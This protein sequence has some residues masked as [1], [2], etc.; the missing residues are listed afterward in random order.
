M[1]ERE[2]DRQTVCERIG[3]K[4]SDRRKRVS[5]LFV[6]FISFYI[7]LSLAF[8]ILIW[9]STFFT[10]FPPEQPSIFYS[11]LNCVKRLIEND[12]N[13][14]QFTVDWN[15]SFTTVRCVYVCVCGE[16]LS[17]DND[18][19]M[20]THSKTKLNEKKQTFTISALPKTLWFC[21]AYERWFNRMQS[22]S[23]SSNKMQLDIG[24]GLN[25]YHN[26]ELKLT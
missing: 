2:R 13:E 26:A 12:N 14:Q 10:F 17:D 18:Q 1:R 5:S 7:T 3:G 4:K 22:S 23:F 11:I 25:C 16:R 19:I 24:F 21:P 20:L 6:D 15:L 9:F 8:N